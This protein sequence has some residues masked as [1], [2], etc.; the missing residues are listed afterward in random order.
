[1]TH[2]NPKLKPTLL[3]F[4]FVLLVNFQLLESFLWKYAKNSWLVGIK[5]VFTVYATTL[6]RKVYRFANFPTLKFSISSP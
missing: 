4:N 5:I 3:Y 1:M 6:S 2:N